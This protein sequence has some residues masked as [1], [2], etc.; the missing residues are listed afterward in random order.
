MIRK[1]H[2]SVISVGNGT[3]CRESEQ[4]ITELIKEIPEKVA[5]YR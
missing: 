3:A 5:R 2:V 1:C 4:V